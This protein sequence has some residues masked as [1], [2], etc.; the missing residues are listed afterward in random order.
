MTYLLTLMVWAFA[1][2][3]DSLRLLKIVGML[4]LGAIAVF[5]AGF[6]LVI[7]LLIWIWSPQR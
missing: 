5:G 2:L 7:I 6:V 3:F 1:D 4:L